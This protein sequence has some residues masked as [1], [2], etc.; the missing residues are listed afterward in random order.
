MAVGLIRQRNRERYL[1]NCLCFKQIVLS[2]LKINE[3]KRNGSIYST[4]TV[5]LLCAMFIE[6]FK[7]ITLVYPSSSY[8]AVFSE[9]GLCTAQL[10]CAMLYEL[11]KTITIQNYS[12]KIV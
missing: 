11:F 3:S 5:Q 6:L 8:S 4:I 7:T 9:M 2:H 12:H 1:S 10:L